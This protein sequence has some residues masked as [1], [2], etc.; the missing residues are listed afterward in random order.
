LVASRGRLYGAPFGQIEAAALA[1]LTEAS[2]AEALRTCPWRM[3]LLEGAWEDAAEGASEA[4]SEADDHGF[5]TAPGDPLMRV[6]ACSGAPFCPQAQGETRALARQLAPHVSGVLHVSGCAKGCALVGPADVTLIA[7][8][9]QFDL[10][11]QGGA[12]D[13]PDMRGLTVE[14]LLSMKF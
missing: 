8:G 3:F 6:H 2:G 13:E 12:G 1:G 4:A 7:R 11:K 5:I 9:N 10:V 14:T